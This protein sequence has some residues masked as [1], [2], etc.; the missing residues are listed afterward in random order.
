MLS[1]PVPVE[2][3]RRSWYDKLV[4]AVLGDEG[5]ENAIPRYALI[6]ERCFAHNG[7]VKESIWEEIR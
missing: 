5:G 6:C 2:P 7:L 3:P 4:D 1:S